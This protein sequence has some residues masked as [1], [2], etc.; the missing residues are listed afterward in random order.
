MKSKE[1]KD[2]TDGSESEGQRGREDR[3]EDTED[4]LFGGGRTTK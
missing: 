4:C 2:M 3:Y 1:E